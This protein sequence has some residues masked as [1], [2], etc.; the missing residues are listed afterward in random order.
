MNFR[1]FAKSF[2]L[3][4]AAALILYGT[5]GWIGKA[6]GTDVS[7]LNDAWRLVAIAVGASLLIGFV[8]PSVRGIKQGD[9]LLAFVRRHVEQNGQSFAVSDAV[10]VTA[11][12]N[13]RQGARIRVQFP[14]G[15]L[16]EGVIESYAG[17][18]T[19]PTIRLTEMETR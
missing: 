9:Q 17:T 13:G 18:L 6:T 10:L 1:V 3:L 19:P 16:A 2:M 14:N 11:L 5:S 4:V 7:F 8:Y 15:L 12:E